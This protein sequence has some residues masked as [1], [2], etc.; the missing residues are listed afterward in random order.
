MS[1]GEGED[2]GKV[3]ELFP[4]EGKWEMDEKDG[5]CGEVKV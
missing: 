1:K 5:T 4:P 3:A 2:A